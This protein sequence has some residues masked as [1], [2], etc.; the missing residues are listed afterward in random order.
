MDTNSAFTPKPRSRRSLRETLQRASILMA[1]MTGSPLAIVGPIVLIVAWAA[2]GPYLHYS[3]SWLLIISTSTAVVE[4][5]MIF[6]IQSSQI[7]DTWEMHLKLDELIRAADAARNQFLDLEALSEEQ[8]E[9]LADSFK[10]EARQ[11]RSSAES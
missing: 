3:N 5:F 1:E 9:R 6:V 11:R 4:M 8:L 7:R 10:H 2:Y